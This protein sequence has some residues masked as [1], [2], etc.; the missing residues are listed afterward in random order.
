[1]TTPPYPPT[2]NVPPSP[3]DLPDDPQDGESYDESALLLAGM[4]TGGF[5][6]VTVY[7]IFPLSEGSVS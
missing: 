6:P 7:E 1:M 4:D 5:T 2:D 3:V